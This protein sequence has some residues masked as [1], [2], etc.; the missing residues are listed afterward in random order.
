[1][2]TITINNQVLIDKLQSVSTHLN[3]T[4]KLGHAIA[5]SFLTVV[6][7]NFDSEGRPAWAGLSAVTLA[8]RKGGKK[9]YQT[10]QLRNSISTKVNK[11]EVVI[12]T[13][14]PKAATHQFGAKQGQYGHN[15]RNVPL[16]WGNIPARPFLPMD[17]DGNLQPEA[18]DALTH[19]V[20]YFYQSLFD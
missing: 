1:M 17:K 20:E 19:D 11:D 9:L 2:T 7:D 10:G 8:K 3:D 16:P 18:E 12:G 5:S 4:S 6:E 15:K 13:N 14:D